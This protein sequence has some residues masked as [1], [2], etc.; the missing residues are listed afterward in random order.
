MRRVDSLNIA[1]RIVLVIAAGLVIRLIALWIVAN[2]AD[3]GWF[4]YAP[5]TNMLAFPTPR[6][7]SPIVTTVV[8]ILGVTVWTVIALRLLANDREDP[9][10]IPPA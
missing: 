2:P 1:Q 3:G 5:N 8:L 7:F 9:S 4:G 10:N 6:R